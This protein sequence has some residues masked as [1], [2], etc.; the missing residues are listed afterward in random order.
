MPKGFFTPACRTIKG[1][2]KCKTTSA[3]IAT[4]PDTEADNGYRRC[5]QEY[6][7]K[8]YFPIAMDWLR[9]D[10]IFTVSARTTTY[11]TQYDLDS[12]MQYSSFQ[13][14]IGSE[15]LTHPVFVRK[16]ND[17]PVPM[18]GMFAPEDAKLSAGDIARIAQMYP[19]HDPSAEAVGA[20]GLGTWKDH[21]M[22]VRLRDDG[23]D[24]ETMIYPPKPSDMA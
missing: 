8:A 20:M 2:K 9:L 1:S 4:P 13:N 23:I 24:F 18:G 19:Q 15:T 5:S 14:S 10:Q 16:D 21:A 3:T 7:A 12:I 17:Q 22:R 11:S 6:V